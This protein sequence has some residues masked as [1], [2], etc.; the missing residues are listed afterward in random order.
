MHSYLCLVGGRI[1][2]DGHKLLGVHA[3]REVLFTVLHGL[4]SLLLKAKDRTRE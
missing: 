1:V 3:L 2:C 4:L